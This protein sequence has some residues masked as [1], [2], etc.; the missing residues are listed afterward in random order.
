MKFITKGGEAL[1]S[2]VMTK[3]IAPLCVTIAV[4]KAF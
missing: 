3:S 2:V 4:I 1:D